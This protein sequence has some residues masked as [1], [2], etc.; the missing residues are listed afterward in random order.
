MRLS[1]KTNAVFALVA[2]I[3]LVVGAAALAQDSEPKHKTFTA[4]NGLNVTVKMVSPVSAKAD[5]QIISVFKHKASGDAYIEAWKDFDDKVGN[6]VSALR[7][8]GEFV[9]ELG[10]T[11]DF[12][13]PP[14][15]ITA[16]HI[17]LIGLGEEKSLSLESLRVVGR[18]AVRESIRLHAHT[19]SFA[20]AIRD[21]GNSTIDVGE[22]DRA[23]AENVLTAYDTERRLQ[24]QGLAEKFEIADFTINAGPQF[25]DGATSQVEQ[26]LKLTGEQL[27]KRDANPYRKASK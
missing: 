5:L 2:T 18:V 23:F 24:A 17:L 4:T 7:D 12:A 9:G 20:P 27:E 11:I 15:S 26:G 10:E 25:F 22:G 19:V 21:Q 6:V 3:G 8:R 16:K 1:N 13:S 14:S